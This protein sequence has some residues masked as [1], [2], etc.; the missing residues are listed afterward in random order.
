MPPQAWL[1]F[2]CQVLLGG[3][4]SR[5]GHGSVVK[6]YGDCKSLKDRVVR[7]LPNGH[8]WLINGGKTDH[9]LRDPSWEPILQLGG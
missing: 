4:G 2:G 7:P 8:S 1:K 5:T 3:L 6:K 9:Y